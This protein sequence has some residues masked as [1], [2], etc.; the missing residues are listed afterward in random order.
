MLHLHRHAPFFNV[1][2]ECTGGEDPADVELVALREV[3]RP[4]Q[5]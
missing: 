1:F 2:L 5:L 3:C 4:R